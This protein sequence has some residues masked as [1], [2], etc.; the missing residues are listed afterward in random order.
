MMNVQRVCPGPPPA[1]MRQG[2]TVLSFCLTDPSGLDKQA[3]NLTEGTQ[4]FP[5]PLKSPR[6]LGAGIQTTLLPVL[7]MARWFLQTWSPVSKTTKWGLED[8][9]CPFSKTSSFHLSSILIGFSH[10]N[11]HPR[12]NNSHLRILRPPLFP[13]H[14][15]NVFTCL[16]NTPRSRRS[17]PKLGAPLLSA[18]K[19]SPC[20]NTVPRLLVNTISSVLQVFFEISFLPCTG[21][22]KARAHIH[23]PSLFF[24]T[25]S[26]ISM[27]SNHA[28]LPRLLETNLA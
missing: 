10:V 25:P 18:I 14:Q 8:S 22:I 26:G 24:L 7:A 19:C 11:Y 23:F 20:S 13:T 4:T 15:R 12:V 27:P 28:F 17:E 21:L 5:G 2:N 16:S 9:M 6:K 3:A 1:V